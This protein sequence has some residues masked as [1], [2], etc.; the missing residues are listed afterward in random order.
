M[1]RA[2]VRMIAR[3]DRKPAV[4]VSGSAIGWYGLW[5]DQVLSESA[6]SHASFSHELCHAWEQAAE[7]GGQRQRRRAEFSGTVAKDGTFLV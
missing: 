1:T 2:V 7:R 4:L 5:Q 6:T 3:L